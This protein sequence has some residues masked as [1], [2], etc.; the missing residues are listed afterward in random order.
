MKKVICFLVVASLFSGYIV[1]AS[2]SAQPKKR[3]FVARG[4]TSSLNPGV[5][6][7]Q[8][9]IF[10]QQDRERIQKMFQRLKNRKPFTKKAP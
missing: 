6:P 3:L 9:K 8:K 7:G 1:S 10:T 4:K 5:K 2:W